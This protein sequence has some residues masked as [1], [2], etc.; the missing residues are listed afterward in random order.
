MKYLLRKTIVSP[1]TYRSQG[2]RMSIYF[3][4]FM[5]LPILIIIILF[6]IHASQSDE[7]NFKNGLSIMRS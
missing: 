2:V 1:I 5:S 4:D 6:E 3:I 7:K